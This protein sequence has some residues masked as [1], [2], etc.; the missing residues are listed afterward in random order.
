MEALRSQSKLQSET[1]AQYTGVVPPCGRIL[2]SEKY[3]LPITLKLKTAQIFLP[4]AGGDIE[5]YF[6][7]ASALV[8]TIAISF[9][10]FS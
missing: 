2:R 10:F 9:P 8:N 7:S 3:L 6:V 4:A 5:S 1:L